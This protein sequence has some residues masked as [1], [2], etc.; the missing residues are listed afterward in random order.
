[1]VFIISWSIAI[2]AISGLIIKKLLDQSQSRSEITWKEFFIG[3]AIIAAITTPIVTK[4]GWDLSKGS[5][6]T[7]SEY[8]N[9]WEV[10]AVKQDIT[11]QR[12]GSCSHSYN[13]DSYTVPVSYSC[14]CDDDG[15]QTCWTVETRY[16]HCPYV[17]VES[18]YLVKTTHG[19]FTIASNRFPTTPQSH[20]WRRSERIPANLLES[21]GIGEP[22]FWKAVKDR[23][24]AGQPGP[25][26]IRHDYKNY[27]LASDSKNLRQYSLDV[28]RF[29]ALNLLPKLNSGLRDFYLADKVYFVGYHPANPAAWQSSL[30]YL[31]AAMGT[32]KQGDVH[33]VIVQNE[34]ASHDPN[35]YAKALRAYWQDTEVFGKDAFSKNGICVIVGTFDGKSVAWAKVFTGMPVGNT[36]LEGYLGKILNGFPLSP[37]SL[38]GTVNRKLTSS[39]R[40]ETVHGEGALETVL[41]G[42]KKP[43]MSFKRY[44]MEGKSGIGPGYLYLMGEIQPKPWQ[45]FWI[46]F[47]AFIVNCV[48][49]IGFAMLGERKYRYQGY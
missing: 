24:E 22:P 18:N 27:I 30:S 25:M 29:T 42:M 39:A 15:C 35:T 34:T 1:M 4:V 28:T 19:D 46:Y 8:L 31:D 5:L 26:T 2:A 44:S 23:I 10:Q 41:F 43:G 16:H 49:W 12:D 14:M 13:C 38:I 47:I 32:E 36:D 7:Y 3:M 11:C 9:G 48:I 20:L 6:V 45:K 40:A 37:E 17:D 33:L 21:V